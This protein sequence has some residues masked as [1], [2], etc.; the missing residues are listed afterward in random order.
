MPQKF[1]EMYQFLQTLGM[2]DS[3]IPDRS[4]G[5]ARSNYARIIAIEFLRYNKELVAFHLL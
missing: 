4:C 1:T 3:S 2:N 5:K